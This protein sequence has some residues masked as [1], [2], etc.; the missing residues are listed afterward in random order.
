MNDAILEIKNLTRKVKGFSLENIN[1]T[2]EPGYIYGLMG[3]NGA[4]KTTLF[5]T[6]MEPKTKYQGE[7]LIKGQNIKQNHTQL[8]ND[9]AYI[10]EDVKYFDHC[11]L[12][13]NASTLGIFYDNF[14]MELFKTTMGQ[15]QVSYGKTYKKLSRGEKMK[16]QLAFHMAHKPSLY[17]LDEV[18]AGM[19]PVF[20]IDFFSILQKLLIDEN[21]S[22]L[23]TSHIKTELETKADYIGIMKAGRLIEMG[24]STEILPRL[25]EIA[26]A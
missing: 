9:I 22:I 3:L 16:F 7:I 15:F 23:M 18:T 2:I 13:E 26:N 1:L 6:I 4:G 20:K 24:E 12:L 5:K 8:M 19:D 25:K 10:S 21:V 17:L 14:D 11:N